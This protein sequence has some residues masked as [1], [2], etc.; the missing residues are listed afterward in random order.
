ML[1]GFR[2]EDSNVKNPKNKFVK[3]VIPISNISIFITIFLYYQ[4]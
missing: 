3:I 1:V 4:I 2:L